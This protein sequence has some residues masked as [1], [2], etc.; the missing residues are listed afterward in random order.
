MGSSAKVTSLTT[1]PPKEFQ[2]VLVFFFWFFA[3]SKIFD[4]F[5]RGKEGTPVLFFFDLQGPTFIPPSF[6]YIMTLFHSVL[7]LMARKRRKK[8]ILPWRALR[9][10]FPALINCLAPGLNFSKIF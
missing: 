5:S 2:P 3:P 9:Y 8:Q 7:Q 10:D 1:K 6:M 4:R